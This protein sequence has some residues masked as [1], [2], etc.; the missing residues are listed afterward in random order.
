MINERSLFLE[1]LDKQGPAERSAFLQQACAGD[2]DL[3][4][5]VEML[6]DA[7][8]S[9]GTFLEEPPAIAVLDFDGEAEQREAP[10]SRIGNY[11]LLEQ[12][13]EGGMGVVYMAE[14][15]EPVR[16]RVA[17]KILK[18]GMDSGQVIA[19]FEAER[20]ALAMMDHQNIAK[21]LDAGT[22]DRGLPYFV[23]ELVH[24][25][26]IT[27]FCDERQLDV[28]ER[29]NLFMQVCHAIQHAH[30]KGVI[31]RDIK[32]TNV[33]VTSYDGVPVPKIIDFGVA[34]A[35][36]QPLTER[37]LF[38]NFGTLIGTLEY[39]APE[40]AEMN[41]LGVDTRS[42]IYSLG[43]L[44][45]ELLTG[46]TPIEH[47]R[48]RQAA[49]GDV[50]RMI[51]EEEP[52]AP[53]TRLSRIGQT[54]PAGEQQNVNH[55]ERMARLVRGELDWIVMRCLEKERSRRYETA[56][57]LAGDV[58]R[59][60]H[61]EPVLAGPPSKLY[62]LRKFS[63]R[64]KG[65]IAAGTAVTVALLA[66]LGA[67]TAGF[68]HAQTQRELA[69]QEHLEA[70]KQKAIAQRNEADAR[71]QA[72]K[73]GAVS[74]FLQDLFLLPNSSQA[75]AEMPVR[76]LFDR[77]AQALEHD[78]VHRD[79]ETEA[80][81]RNVLGAAYS[82]LGLYAAAEPQLRIGLEIRERELG[83]E[84]PEVAV[85]LYSLANMYSRKH[86]HAA[87]EPLL[88]R[89]LRIR[90]KAFGSEHPLVADTLDHLAMI[91]ASQSN[92]SEAAAFSE[93]ALAIRE[94]VYGQ[95]SKPVADSLYS[96]AMSLGHQGK[97]REAEQAARESL[98][99]YTKLEGPENAAVF[100]GYNLLGNILA[101]QQKYEEAES[102]FRHSLAIARKIKGDT[103]PDLLL[104]L[105][106]LSR[107]LDATEDKA[108]LRAIEMERLRIELAQVNSD[109]ATRPDDHHLI[110]QRADLHERLGK[111]EQAADDL[112]KALELNPLDHWHWFRRCALCLYLGNE[113]EYQHCANEML[114]RFGDNPRPQISERVAKLALLS[115]RFDGDIEAVHRLADKAVAATE[116]AMF[117]G[118][119]KLTKAWSEYRNGNYESALAWAERARTEHAPL[120]GKGE[121]TALLLM[122]MA[123][124]QLQQHEQAASKFA[125]AEEVIYRD[126]REPGEADQGQPGETVWLY[127]LWQ[128]ARSVVREGQP[129]ENSARTPA[130]QS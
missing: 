29:L 114:K 129:V 104:G 24:G 75:E 120:N 87:A 92:V 111:F 88:R 48:L 64:H 4:Q 96:R 103:H 27:K 2:A 113:A 63:R 74:R 55:S 45:Y 20:Q 31:H 43:V 44:L 3:R 126:H 28:R 80:A 18:P 52:P 30:Q 53:S 40:Q 16:R 73:A 35:I 82:G 7:H 57:E 70:E 102:A 109:L 68:I 105:A 101:D 121:I 122:S 39:M 56:H 10:G 19:R 59:Y 107:V 23:M 21:V 17:V 124:Q 78:G 85:S 54:L 115:P 34:K 38:T 76:T 84:H 86:E 83:P 71:R 9:V 97:Y 81:I 6:L 72:E 125:Q 123:H 36:G 33:L 51:R 90:E 93:R 15:E 116:P 106:N 108:E 65:W 99:L 60:L 49:F 91:C 100:R 41:A 79:P 127:I 77:A 25:T 32:P 42:D 5:R 89:A 12:I 61:D 62:R 58:Q 117:L 50:L 8:Q 130:T 46:T 118:W 119:F 110:L 47:R 112:K 66:G 98:E 11:K 69:E 128:E 95:R 22:T 1:A 94:K 67:A 37:T 26:P 14:Q 13:G